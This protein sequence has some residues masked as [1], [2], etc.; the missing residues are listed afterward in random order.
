LS[1]DDAPAAAAWADAV[2]DGVLPAASAAAAARV[3]PG[4]VRRQPGVAP[5]MP[6]TPPGADARGARPPVLVAG[7]LHERRWQA[8]VR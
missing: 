1:S 4:P 2:G 7:G 6:R 8:R 3:V 5:A